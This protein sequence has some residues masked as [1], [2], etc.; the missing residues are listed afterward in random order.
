MVLIFD[1]DGVIVDNYAWHLDAFIEFGKRHG[2]EITKEEFG[3]YFGS[4]NHVIMHSLFSKK[5]TKEETDALADE[6]ESIYRQLYRPFIK[7]VE[8]LPEFLKYASNL[9]I[10]IA[11]ATSAPSANVK[12]T[13]ESIGLEKYFRLITDSSMIK[14]GKPDPEIYMLTAA[15]LEV[16]PSECMVFEDSVPGILS[17]Q[18]AGMRVIGVATTHKPE[19]L[20]MYVNEIIMNFEAAE[21]LFLKNS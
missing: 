14:H 7:P 21:E 1:M 9:G 13:L 15:K 18:N 16:N 5:L 2:L 12:F 11:L 17:A 4:T 3:K 8:G 10:A 6:K 19:E 20:F